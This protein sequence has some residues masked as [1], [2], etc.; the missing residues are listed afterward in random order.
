V[1]GGLA[2]LPQTSGRGFHSRNKTGPYWFLK[3]A[4]H[5][6]ETAFSCVAG[7]SSS[8]NGLKASFFVIF[9]RIAIVISTQQIRKNKAELKSPA[10]KILYADN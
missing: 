2:N 4:Q 8:C 6:N 5:Y 9:F 3:I 1:G 10:L 7:A